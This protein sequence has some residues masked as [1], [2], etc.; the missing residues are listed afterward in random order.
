MRVILAWQEEDPPTYAKA[1]SF[2]AVLINNKMWCVLA[3]RT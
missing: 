2:L 3:R 1:W